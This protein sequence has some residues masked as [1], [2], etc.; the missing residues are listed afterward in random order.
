MPQLDESLPSVRPSFDAAVAEAAAAGASGLDVEL[1]ASGFNR[2]HQNDL[3]AFLD[4][5]EAHGKA[6]ISYGSRLS[7]GAFIV[8]W[9]AFH[10]PVC[11]C[12]PSSPATSGSVCLPV[13]MH[14]CVCRYACLPACMH[15]CTTL[16]TPV[17]LP[18]HLLAYHCRLVIV[19]HSP[20]L[21]LILQAEMAVKTGVKKMNRRVK[22]KT[23]KQERAAAAAKGQEA[24]LHPA[25]KQQQ[26][27]RQRMGTLLLLLLSD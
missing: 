14:V 10:L 9:H 22:N 26:L 23:V 6:V 7:V 17:C 12:E 16:P 4:E 11:V 3:E 24:M 21:L 18:V 19:A 27:Q 20:C 2:Q 5:G 13:C 8:L 25:A 15:A 1:A